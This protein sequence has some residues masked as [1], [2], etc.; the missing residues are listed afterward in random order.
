MI[1][2][3]IRSQIV[4]IGAENAVRRVMRRWE[5]I[6]QL[7]KEEKCPVCHGKRLNA[8]ALACRVNGI[9]I[10]EMC[11]MDFPALLRKWRTPPIPSR[12][13][14]PGILLFKEAAVPHFFILLSQHKFT[15]HTSYSDIP[16]FNR[17][18]PSFKT[19]RGQAMFIRR[20][21]DPFPLNSLPSER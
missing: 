20:K 12:P 4:C 14:I 8:A 7:L 1:S 21:F 2:Q 17:V 10:D 16:C 9:S 15:A 5:L 11:E 19:L 13:G 6:C 18:N 3:E